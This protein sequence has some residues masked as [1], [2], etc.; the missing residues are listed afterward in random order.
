MPQH[1]LPGLQGPPVPTGVR[2]TVADNLQHLDP[3]FLVKVEQRLTTG[4]WWS[5]RQRQWENVETDLLTTLGEDLIGA[6]L[7]G[8]GGDAIA[9]AHDSV[10]KVA[11]AH[12]RR[13][14]I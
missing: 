4:D 11:K 10:L 2:I 14:G 3:G 9:M 12:R 6:Y 5:L 7:Y 1:T 13:H 8:A